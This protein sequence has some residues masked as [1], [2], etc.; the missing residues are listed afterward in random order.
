MATEVLK[1]LSLLDWKGIEASL[2]KRGYAKTGPIL[3]PDECD[4]L[5]RLYH[6]DSRFRSRIDMHRYR[7][8]EGDYKYFKYPLPP[9]VENL[10]THVY[11]LLASIANEWASALSE[12]FRYPAEHY[13]FLDYCHR[14]GQH[15][16]TP[17][18]LHYGPGG[19]NCLHQDLY[20]DVVFP[21]QLTVFLSRKD[22][23]IGG[24]FLLVEQRPRAQSRGEAVPTELGE[25]IIFTTRY[26]P[27]PSARGYYKVNIRHGVSTVRSGSRFALGVIFHDAR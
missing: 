2:W 20:G 7:F 27:V 11:P 17:L 6:D 4:G 22:D 8:G 1:R 26:R 15:K 19:Y 21:L 16:P 14:N 5:V 23:Y 10:R 24:E 3:A 13:V 18:L 25:M 12:E 9:L